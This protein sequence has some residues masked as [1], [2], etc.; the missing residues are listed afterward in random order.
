M[1]GKVG[2]SA[3]VCVMH[4]TL[5]HA[6]CADWA[7]P[8]CTATVGQVTGCSTSQ[9][10]HGIRPHAEQ[11]SLTQAA[12]LTPIVVVWRPCTAAEH[13]AAMP[14]PVF[15]GRPGCCST[16]IAECS[17]VLPPAHHS[18]S[19]PRLLTNKAPAPV[20]CPPPSWPGPAEIS[21]PGWTITAHRGEYG[22]CTAS[23]PNRNAN[24]RKVESAGCEQGV[25]GVPMEIVQRATF[26]TPY[27]ISMNIISL[28]T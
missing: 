11:N 25:R 4:T 22:P 17:V 14:A 12:L 20:S 6:T 8:L 26:P 24:A 7:A 21:A 23:V 13:S 9:L 16:T 10:T 2:S 19:S 5:C 18:G 15:A 3:V 28:A 27:I 1:I